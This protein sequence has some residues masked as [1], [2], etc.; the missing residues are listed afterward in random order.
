[1]EISY[2][3]T[4]LHE[5]ISQKILILW[6]MYVLTI[7]SCMAPQADVARGLT[8]SGFLKCL[9]TLDNTNAAEMQPRRERF[10]ITR[11]CCSRSRK[12]HI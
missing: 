1:M 11:P 3:Y 12:P 5:A 8:R 2:V 10:S 4:R 6:I 7:S 9:P